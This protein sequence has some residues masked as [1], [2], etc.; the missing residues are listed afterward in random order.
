MTSGRLSKLQQQILVWLWR[1][2][3]QIRFRPPAHSSYT[4]LMREMLSDK[5]NVSRS[6]R[7]LERKGFIELGRSPAGY[8]VW[9]SLT[10]KG[11]LQ[12]ANLAKKDA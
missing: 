7:T 3:Q 4:D 11:V 10:G 6:I 12:A 5:S 1:D 2:A 9:V 8:A